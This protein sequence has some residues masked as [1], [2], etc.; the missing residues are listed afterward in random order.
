MRTA[1]LFLLIA[2]NTLA[3]TTGCKPE[4][5]ITV[6]RIPKAVSGLEGIRDAAAV[7]PNQAAPPTTATKKAGQ[8]T[9]M[10]V[11]LFQRSD[12]AWFFKISGSP[13]DVSAT[14]S[15]WTDFVDK[16]KFG[17]Q[18]GDQK[19]EEPEWTLPD[20]WTTGPPA[21]FRFATVKLPDS[22]IE[23]RIS[24]L[25]GQQDLLSNVNRWRT[26]QLGLPAATADNV[27]AQFQKKE[28]QGGEYLLF[29]QQ[30]VS[31]GQS[32]G[33][34]F[35]NR[36]PAPPATAKASPAQ[37]SANVAAAPKFDLTPP[38]GFE[39]GKT[40]PMV[41]ARF[42]KES[43][44][45]AVQI[46]VVPLTA[47]NKWDDNVNFWR[48]S[49]GLERIDDAEIEKDSS[50]IEV[51]GIEGR[52]IE[53]LDEPDGDVDQEADKGLVGVMVKK[54]DLAWFFKMLGPR[55]LVED[56]MPVFDQFLESFKFKE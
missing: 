51:S 42:V 35:M 46:S 27:D 55:G 18:S 36:R 15:K 13:E 10:V 26:S 45:G 37:V 44:Q 54:G 7:S 32:M 20:G 24:K 9:R 4:E 56:N 19:A 28:G 11:A 30:G 39:L 3:A 34:P 33:G 50:A 31:T 38:K 2:L 6:Y 5:Q 53:L 29:D 48:Q 22:E 23:I 25:G 41:V 17:E 12:A 49:V 52:R 40:S 16:V 47:V 1:S 21:P 43:D 14:Q 8:A